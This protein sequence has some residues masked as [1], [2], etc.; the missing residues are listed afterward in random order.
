MTAAP[1]PTST[2]VD[3][4]PRPGPVARAVL[5]GALTVLL[6]VAASPA[7]AQDPAEERE[8]VR[9][10][11]AETEGQLDVLR[12]S[13]ADVTAELN[14]LADAVGAAQAELANAERG[15]AEAEAE[16]TRLD[17]ELAALD[18]QLSVIRGDLE[19]AA[20]ESY[21]GGGRS[22]AF[23]GLADHE[24][25][26]AAVRQALLDVTRGD[27]EGLV[28][29]LHGAEAERAA[30]RQEAEQARADA[31][32]ARDRAASQLGAVQST[33]ADQQ[34]LASD[35]EARI[36][37]ALTEAAVLE[38]QDAELSAEIR[39]QQQA[40]ARA[41]PPP[42]PPPTPTA[43]ADD[44]DNDNDDT[45]V[46]DDQGDDTPSAPFNPPPLPE[47]PGGIVTVSGIQ[48]AASIAGQLQGLM[49]AA[50]ADD[51]PLSGTGW[52]DPQR[53]I[54]L[55]MQNCG[56]SYYAIYQMPPTQCSPETAIPGTSKHEVG[57]AID[58]SWGGQFI[59][60]RNSPGFQWL[61]ANA[62]SFGF[63]NLPSE[64]WHWSTD[65]S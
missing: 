61:A 33:Q 3:R 12:A 32:S 8:R 34:A 21:I 41:L 43:P 38:E 44:N 28:E 14:R 57:L 42:P 40:L 13:Q 53:Q 59:Q 23:G 30:A 37:R 49:A 24:P 60:S 18:Q 16:V 52:R 56:T 2:P 1:T 55:R 64:P 9:Q 10:E 25:N 15:V 31:Q 4:R 39:A 22:D 47:P 45:V 35:V 50:A 65:G 63:A 17:E 5:L 19:D 7:A 26:D 20:V 48:V 54:E 58:F 46:S 29:S 36:N 27:L 51:A 6:V 11:Q 62:P